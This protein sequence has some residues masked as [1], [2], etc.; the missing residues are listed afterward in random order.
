MKKNLFLFVVLLAMATFTACKDE[1][2]EPKPLTRAQI[3]TSHD[4]K[5]DKVIEVSSSDTVE[6]VIEPCDKDNFQTFRPDGILVYDQ[7]NKKCYE[8]T[9]Q[10]SITTWS[11]TEDN[12]VL[13]I[14]ILERPI[15]E[16]NENKLVYESKY[17]WGN[18]T[19]YS[20]TTLIKY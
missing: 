7:G 13:K 6:I 14:A 12:K 17:L 15:L 1:K 20:T 4:W 2:D 11:L 16:L 9:D 3:L 5:V 18:D 19:I 10:T 8:G